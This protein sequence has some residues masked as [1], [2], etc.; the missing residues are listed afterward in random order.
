MKILL[1]EDDRDL[2][3][4]LTF[5]LRR[6]GFE[7]LAAFDA[8]MALGHLRDSAADLVLLDVNLGT[9]SGFDLLKEIRGQS[10]IPVIVLTGR[11][12]EE[13][14]VKGLDLGADDY[15]TKPFSHRELVARIRANLRRAEEPWSPGKPTEAVVQVGS[16]IINSA[17]H[18]AVIDGETLDL[19][20]TEFR[21]LRYLLVNA[22]TVVPIRAIARHV[23]GY[24]DRGSNDV[25]RTTLHRLRRKLNDSPMNP[26]LLHTV[27][28]IGVMLKAAPVD[29]ATA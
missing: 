8:P 13:D 10:Q 25:V 19:T 29:E 14:K 17:Q 9:T 2:V 28:G 11:S 6:A 12:S 22:N 21:L 23:W 4:L 15:V 24:E 3:D 7:T 5:L 26:R 27:P 16:I 20:V 18:S 1:V